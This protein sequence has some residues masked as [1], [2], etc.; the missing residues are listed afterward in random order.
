MDH[1]NIKH[2]DSFSI[3]DKRFHI[4]PKMLYEYAGLCVGFFGCS[5]KKEKK[6]VFQSPNLIKSI[7][8]LNIFILKM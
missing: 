4:P 5:T 3:N 1:E 6:K 2:I 8:S 7:N